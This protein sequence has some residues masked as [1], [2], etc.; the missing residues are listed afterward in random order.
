MSRPVPVVRWFA[1]FALLVFS[2]FSLF[3]CSRNSSDLTP[4]IDPSIG[5]SAFISADQSMSQGNG[6][7]RSSSAGDTAG[8][9]ENA[10]PPQDPSNGAAAQPDDRQVEEGDIYRLLGDHLIVNLNAFRGLQV[11]DVKDVSLPA[12]IGRLAIWGSPVEMYLVD[13]R[14]LVLLNGYQNYY[15][16]R[17]DI[18][19]EAY[20]G[21]MVI[22]VDLSDPA[23]PTILSKARVP[24]VIQTSRLTRGNGKVALYAVAN[25]WDQEQK[26][27]VRSFALSAAGQLVEATTLDLGGYVRDIQATPQA[28]LVARQKPTMSGNL[29]MGEQSFIT[30]VDI[31]SPDGTMKQGAEIPV[32]GLIQHKTNMDLYKN[33]LR[34]VSAGP[35]SGSRVNHLETFDV[36]DLLH[37]QVVDHD[38]FGKDESLFATLFLGNKGFFVTYLRK[39]PFHAFEIDDLG[40]AQAR[41]E[42]VISGWNDFF[43]PV[44]ADTR[45]VGIGTNDE[46]GS[47]TMAVSLYDVTSLTNPNPLLARQE[48]AADSSW[49][50]ASWDDKAFSVL[51]NAVTIPSIL[52]S[53]TETGM[54]LLPFSGYNKDQATYVA[55]VQIFTF[56]NKTLSRRGIMNHGT[57]VRRSFLANPAT[58]ANLSEAELSLFDHADPGAP[59][60]KGR[61]ELS[62]NYSDFFLFG[63]FGA[64]LKY[65][66]D[67]YAWW[68]GL[69]RRPDN[70][71]EIVPLGDHPDTAKPVARVPIGSGARVFQVGSLAVAV[72]SRWV[73]SP[74][75]D[76]P[77]YE[78]ELHA[79]DLGDPAHPVPAGQLITGDLPA[80]T[81]GWG[82]VEPMMD[83]VGP[84]CPGCGSGYAGTV[85]ALVVGA[86]L[87]FPA[88]VWESETIGSE[89]VC[90]T[91]PNSS[92]GQPSVPPSEGSPP[93]PSSSPSGKGTSSGVGAYDGGGITCVSVDGGKKQCSGEILHCIVRADG[94]TQCS[95]VDPGS[96]PTTT[97]CQS[98]PRVRSWRRLELNLVDF[99]N[100]S[101]PV[102]RHVATLP[103]VEDAVNLL[104]KGT[105]LYE[106]Y[107]IP[108]RITGDPRPFA[109][110]HFRRIALLA[111]A[112][113]VVGKGINIPGDLLEVEGDLVFTHDYVWSPKLQIES[114][115]NKLRLKDDRAY[116]LARLRFAQ[117]SV[118]TM[119]LDGKGHA[120]VSH[121]TA[122]S[123]SGMGVDGNGGVSVGVASPVRASDAVSTSPGGGGGA[124]LVAE[125]VDRPKDTLSVLD[126]ASD[127]FAVIAELEIDQWAELREARENRALFQVPG[128]LMVVNLDDPAEPLAQAF[129]PVTGWPQSLIIHDASVIVAAG[130]Y[131]MYRFP[132]DLVNISA[133]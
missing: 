32:S 37:P 81:S 39:D 50:E 2:L 31:A 40:R 33:I 88:Y 19:V 108:H 126:V 113:P 34:V 76:K 27:V 129:F 77:R 115:L 15:G 101:Q 96:V 18:Q 130:R 22:S 92:G 26:T 112:E 109:R 133:N 1:P 107:K 116:L 124:S 106:S 45:L 43:K 102:V 6:Q 100:A 73:A 36:T 127:K 16:N 51:E 117:R 70:A 38:T 80:D 59:K 97:Q 89:R 48:V 75:T 90:S 55:A 111:P 95:A 28:L 21:G 71:L 122:T 118:M 91:Y 5:E 13:N 4:D 58:V 123:S 114:A 56:S 74:S 86:T 17:D 53:V 24:G 41:S 8:S 11:I 87:V 132:L 72:E 119:L 54:V 12:I 60:E 30:L 99:S 25:Q 46:N 67:D 69:S 78:V 85:N 125:P 49:S 68:G 79:Y 110:Y 35:W 66:Q 105:D 47:R 120:L 64:R 23:A 61:V 20:E 3:S 52:G 63:D 98:Y 84:S 121:R 42:F 57:T 94:Q 82:G 9:A 44:S 7:G 83:R 104:V 10:L 103:K 62:P 93:S 65:D 131:G 14:A 128:G 29:W